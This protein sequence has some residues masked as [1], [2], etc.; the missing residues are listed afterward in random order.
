MRRV[1]LILLPVLLCPFL[2]LAEDFYV[3]PAEEPGPLIATGQPI[4][5]V[6]VWRS[7]DEGY[8]FL[9]SNFDADSLRVAL[10]EGE[11]I[12]IDGTA[13]RDGEV[14]GLFQP[15]RTVTV[16]SPAGS[17]SLTV[18]QSANIPALFLATD[19]GRSDF[20]HEGKA[21]REP[22]A[23]LMVAADG[24][25]VYSGGLEQLR[26]RGNTT[27]NYEK[28]PY[29]FKLEDKTALVGHDEARSWALLANYI[30]HSLLRNS[31]A[32]SL[33]EAVGLPS[34]PECAPADV[35]L[36]N[37]YM[38]SYLLCETVSVG[39]GRVDIADLEKATEDVNELALE[40][41]PAV[42]GADWRTVVRMW[43]A[44]GRWSPAA[45]YWQGAKIPND[46]EDITG[47]YLLEIGIERDWDDKVSRFV[48]NSGWPMVVREPEYASA[49][50]VNYIRGVFQRLDDA[51]GDSEQGWEALLEIADTDSFV[52][53]YVLE[54]LLMNYDGG[55][56][57]QYFYKDADSRDP[58]IYCGPPWDYDNILGIN[59]TV[60]EPDQFYVQVRENSPSAIFPRLWAIPEFREAAMAAYREEFRPLL[61]E[62]L[63]SV[64]PKRLP[65]IEESAAVIGASAEMNFIRWP[66]DYSFHPRVRDTGGTW[67]ENVEDL[68]AFLEQRVMFLDEAWQ[69]T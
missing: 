39:K 47:G 62:L 57:S 32:L 13:L 6:S 49:A 61:D 11:S 58:L 21:N 56:G 60:S 24:Q 19:S 18:L 50:Q 35:Y 66:I 26:I 48:T 16:D 64:P 42:S 23:L 65:S 33:S 27:A 67:E 59:V 38:G 69:A 25:T 44:V 55:T 52:R 8:L 12:R 10:P 63:G 5:A 22:G 17:Y 9:P 40:R 29:Q 2:A 37:V 4:G 51:I 31:L 30:D 20:I 7:G 54:E 14:S 3:M 43:F 45:G 36:N 53:K 15:G 68:L 28:K 41:Y 1:L 34:V 46:P